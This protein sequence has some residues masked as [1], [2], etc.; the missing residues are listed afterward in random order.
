MKDTPIRYDYEVSDP[1][2]DGFARVPADSVAGDFAVLVPADLNARFLVLNSSPLATESEAEAT[3]ELARWTA[4]A[5]D[6]GCE[7]RHGHRLRTRAVLSRLT[8]GII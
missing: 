2:T 4:G 7:R 1:D 3:T 5:N 8:E 6:H